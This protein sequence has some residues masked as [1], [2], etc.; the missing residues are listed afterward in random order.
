MTIIAVTIL[1]VT[2]PSP[3]TIIIHRQQQQ[4]IIRR[5]FNKSLFNK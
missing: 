4:V 3:N 1:L 5:Q 2:L